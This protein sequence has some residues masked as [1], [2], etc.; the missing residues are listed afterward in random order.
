MIVKLKYIYNH[1]HNISH[2]AGS[3][4]PRPPF[5]AKPGIIPDMA[6]KTTVDYFNLFIDKDVKNIIH[7]ETVRFAEQYLK[8]KQ[9]YLTEHRTSRALDWVKQPMT[10]KEVDV[11]LAIT[12]AMGIVGYPSLRYYKALGAMCKHQHK[13]NV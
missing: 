10:K 3:V 2:Q 8:S 11:F 6:G 9:E 7:S 4:T 13:E 5:T 1:T 12:I